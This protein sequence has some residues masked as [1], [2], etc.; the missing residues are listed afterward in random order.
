MLK[1]LFGPFGLPVL[2]AVIA[3]VAVLFSRLYWRWATRSAWLGNGG[4]LESAST[5]CAAC[6]QANLISGF[7]HYGYWFQPHKR[8]WWAFEPWLAVRT[9]ACV[10]CGFI[11]SHLPPSYIQELRPKMAEQ[12]NAADSR[13]NRS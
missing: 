3:V 11:A 9:V 8:A 6:G 13:L 2:A 5:K 10:D 4:D 12:S 1:N 7:M